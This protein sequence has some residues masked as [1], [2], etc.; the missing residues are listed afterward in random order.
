MIYV[1]LR[2]HETAGPVDQKNENA[3]ILWNPFENHLNHLWVFRDFTFFTT[4][5]RPRKSRNLDEECSKTEKN[6]TI[7]IFF[8]FKENTEIFHF[9]DVQEHETTKN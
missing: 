9:S 5:A 6:Y 2:S 4:L 8:F 1:V 7:F 3:E